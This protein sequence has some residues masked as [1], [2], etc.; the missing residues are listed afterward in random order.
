M[1]Q[2]KVFGSIGIAGAA[3]LLVAVVIS[4]ITFEDG[5]FSPL[6]G[7]YSELGLYTNGYFSA[8][9]ALIFNIGMLLLGLSLSAGMVYWGIRQNSWG[10]GIVS[11]FGLLTGVLAAS[12]AVFSLNFAR[13]H[14]IIAA[15]FSSA[16]FLFGV[17]YIIASIITGRRNIALLLTAFFAAVCGALFGGY[18]FSGSMMQ[19]FVEDA[20]MVGRLVFM[21]FA[22]LGWL[23]LL[24]LMALLVLFSLELL[25]DRQTARFTHLAE[26][27]HRGSVRDLDF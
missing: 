24:L 19:V 15:V 12:L 8:S 25:L 7:F 9:S 16:V 2:N 3:L 21:P 1:N 23:S 20:S 14:Y 6:S 10:F 22:V 17:S 5:V 4:I 11:F 13:Y 26:K 18:V 27:V